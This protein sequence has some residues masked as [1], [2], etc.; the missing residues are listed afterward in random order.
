M[1]FARFSMKKTTTAQ[2]ADAAEEFTVSD[3]VVGH[4]REGV[5]KRPRVKIQHTGEQMFLES[6]KFNSV[7]R[8][9]TLAK[10]RAHVG[11]G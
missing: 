10:G 5:T 2:I 3:E 4:G 9:V 7:E 11:S 6:G 1:V 8:A